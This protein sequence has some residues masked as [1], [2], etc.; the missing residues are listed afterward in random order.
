MLASGPEVLSPMFPSRILLLLCSHIDTLSLPAL[1]ICN[2]TG[3]S[4]LSERDVLH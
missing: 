3:R 4:N 2:Y 1:Q